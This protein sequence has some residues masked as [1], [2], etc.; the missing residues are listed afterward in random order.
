MTATT[1]LDFA[2][3]VRE[4]IERYGYPVPV[5]IAKVGP[6]LLASMTFERLRKRGMDTVDEDGFRKELRSLLRELIAANTQALARKQELDREIENVLA[7]TAADVALA[8]LKR[9]GGPITAERYLD[10]LDT[11]RGAR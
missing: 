8:R 5:P 6:T 11:V 3:V 4:E 2:P 7:N 9:A 1:R 10:E